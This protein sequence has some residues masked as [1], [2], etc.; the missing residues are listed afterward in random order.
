[1]KNR[2]INRIKTAGMVFIFAAFV[3]CAQTEKAEQVATMEEARM[4]GREA[5]RLFINRRW[6][7]TAELQNKLLEVRSRRQK[8][9]S[10]GNRKA[11]DAFDSTF[12]STLRTVNPRIARKLLEAEERRTDS[13]TSD[14]NASKAETGD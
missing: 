13:D 7:D 10:V 6:N 8:Y 14:N 12:V 11:G 2:I 1:M 9:D 4:D 5:A 3:S